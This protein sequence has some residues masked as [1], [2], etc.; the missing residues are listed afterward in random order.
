MAN[1]DFAGTGAL[2][3]SWTVAMGSNIARDGGQCKTTTTSADQVAFYNALTFANNQ[4]SKWKAIVGVG[5]GS[6]GIVCRANG[7]GGTFGCYFA[8]AAGIHK[9]VNG[10]YGG[11]ILA[12]SIT[13]NTDDVLEIR[14]IGSTIS[15]YLNGVLAGS[16]TDATH[17]SGAPG[18]LHYT[19]GSPCIS[20]DWEG[21]DL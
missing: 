16:V 2:A 19:T 18:I 7:S 4:Y 14:A 10:S 17:A 15:R 9:F 12:D 8:N 5:S 3:S 1:E 13:L 6:P 20:D 21:G 11:Q